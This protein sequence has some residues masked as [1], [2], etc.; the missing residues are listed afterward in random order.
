MRAALQRLIA[1]LVDYIQNHHQASLPEILNSWETILSKVNTV[2]NV[3]REKGRKGLDRAIYKTFLKV[4]NDF[5]PPNYRELKD[6]LLDE[7]VL[8]EILRKPRRP[9]VP[10]LARKR[11]EGKEKVKSGFIMFVG[12]LWEDSKGMDKA[13]P[14]LID[15][16]EPLVRIALEHQERNEDEEEPNV[17]TGAGIEDEGKFFHHRMT[18]RYLLTFSRFD[19]AAR[20]S[21]QTTVFISRSGSG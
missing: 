8:W 1:V 15:L 6:C 5:L 18:M 12:G 14:W 7:A 10:L 19:D 4:T 2:R 20:T 17:E 21:P 11:G 13:L 9:G 3:S 16:F